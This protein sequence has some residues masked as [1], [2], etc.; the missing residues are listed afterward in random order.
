[1]QA[2]V[3]V[4][5]L[6]SN[7]V[8]YVLLEWLAAPMAA[9]AAGDPVAM[10]E[11]SKATTELTCERSGFLIPLV[12]AG[13]TCQPGDVVALVAA[14]AAQA[15][16]RPEAEPEV[17]SPAVISRPAQEL[18]ERH[19]VP[20]AAVEALGKRI[21]KAADIEALVAGSP[22]AADA[23]T[24]LPS[25]QLAVARA[26]SLSHRTIP[27][28]FT[29][30]KV[31]ARQ[32]AADARRIGERSRAFV[33]L[34]EMLVYV[35]ARLWREHPS[36]FAALRDDLVVEPAT[37]A[38]IGVTIDVGT[39]LYVPVVR[40]ADTLDVAAIARRLMEMRVRA[41]R[42]TMTDAD[43]AGARLT[44]S[45]QRE[46]GIVLARPIIFPGQTCTLSMCALQ[47]ELVPGPDGAPVPHEYFYLGL[48]YD[49]R[50]INGHE[51]MAFLGAIRNG[52]ESGAIT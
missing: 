20:V 10:I 46:P 22:D 29:V 48:V 26:V 31:S 44:I 14:Q 24:A 43:L 11:T 9:V 38:D 30:A 35:V 21:V 5:H 25:A 50:L 32:A 4:P 16:P 36:C 12:Q 33:G 49:H 23:G 19:Q 28:A 27:N 8:S 42:R 51:A 6:N 7:D 1:M 13:A 40:D 41:L 2:D 47:Q 45:L 39:G 52:L 3:V 18:I 17:P 15:A 37:A 34:P